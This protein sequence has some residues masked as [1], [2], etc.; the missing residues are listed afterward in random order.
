MAFI[1]SS[2]ALFKAEAATLSSSLDWRNYWRVHGTSWRHILE[3]HFEIVD[4]LRAN[5]SLWEVSS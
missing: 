4:H 5:S 1:P 3:L 2:S